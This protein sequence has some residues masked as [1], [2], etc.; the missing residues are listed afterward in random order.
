MTQVLSLSFRPKRFSELV[1]Q[2]KL[3]ERIRGH[4]QQRVPTAWMLIGQKGAGKTTIAR[5]L[6]MALQCRHQ[7]EI[8][9]VCD[10]CYK[11]KS[12]FNIVEIN[13][14]K[15]T[16]KN[17]LEQILSGSDLNPNPGS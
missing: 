11:K 14:A 2:E 16:S 7:D 3:V 13:G 5:I 8:G 15:F 9:E 10:A 17:E 6:A 12:S 4:F 1:G